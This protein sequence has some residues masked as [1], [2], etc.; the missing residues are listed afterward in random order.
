MRITRPPFLSNLFFYS[1]DGQLFHTKGRVGRNFEAEGR[2]FADVQ[3]SA[4]IHVKSKKKA[5][6][7]A[8]VYSLFQQFNEKNGKIF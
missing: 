1:R 3:F 8:D 4:Q 7:P 6:T 2:T 5:M